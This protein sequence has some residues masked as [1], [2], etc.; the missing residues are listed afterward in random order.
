MI[1]TLRRPLHFGGRYWPA[2]E[3]DIPGMTP[4]LLPKSASDPVQLRPFVERQNFSGFGKSPDL[5]AAEERL[6]AVGVPQPIPEAT[7]FGEAVPA[8]VGEAATMAEMAG[9]AALRKR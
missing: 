3:H 9:A 4:E 1:V 6:R 2:G 5:R 8:A 7:T